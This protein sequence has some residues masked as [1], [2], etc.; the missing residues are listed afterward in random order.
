MD[1]FPVCLFSRIK[2]NNKYRT[3]NTSSDYFIPCIVTV[4]LP[5]S[6][7]GHILIQQYEIMIEE[8]Y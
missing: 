2:K 4:T 6:I 8:P 3:E 7:K 5:A 1:T